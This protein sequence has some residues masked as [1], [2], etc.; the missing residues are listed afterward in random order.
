LYETEGTS[1]EQPGRFAFLRRTGAFEERLVV[2]MASRLVLA[3]VSLGIAAALDATVGELEGPRRG[4]YG[5]VVVAFLATALTGLWLPRIRRPVRFAGL[6]IAIDIGIVT[7]LVQFSGGADSPFGFLYVVV[8]F[9]GALLFERKGALMTAGLGGLAHGA[10]LLAGASGDAPIGTVVFTAWALNAGAVGGVALL[11]SFLASELRRTGEALR[12]RTSDLAELA[13]LHE[14]TVESLMSGLL[15][16]DLEGC[17]TSFNPEA[18]RITGTSVAEALGRD[19]DGVIPGLREMME[20]ELRAGT[21]SG[22][23][24]MTYSSRSGASIYLGLGAYILRDESGG[25]SGHVV[26]F[27]DVTEVV[28]MEEEL[29]RSE[30]LAAAGELS[31][32]IAHEIRNPLA[33]ISGSIQLLQ[34]GE[35]GVEEPEASRRLMNIVVRET[36][37]L[38]ALIT[39]FLEY[40]RPGPLKLESVE[41]AAVVEEMLEV[42]QAALP[43]GVTV[44]VDIPSGLRVRG[45]SGQLRQI[46]WNLALN[47]VQAMPDGGVLRVS[48]SEAGSLVSQ[49]PGDGDRNEG[50]EDGWVEVMVQDEG[51][52]I[53]QGRM[54]QVFDPFF[55]T[56][57]EGTGLGLPTVHRSVEEHGGSLRLESIEGSGTTVRVRLPG[58]G[59]RT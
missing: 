45:D 58:S 55:T 25:P 11:G 43:E 4:L 29:R 19:V 39:D 8:A 53:P 28:A 47:G 41:L 18:E 37:R 23:S 15:T 1:P 27:Q 36:D 44:A 46:L 35:G 56:K 38:N 9:Y 26:I 33:A 31:A 40:A 54:D 17:V 49:E 57:P 13:N 10:V 16:T 22:R 42:F 14:R 48:A 12:Q 34:R 51:M 52:G 5:T 59:E 32:S 6:N 30:R 50:D 24:R 7:T 2:L 3:F 21:G 20:G